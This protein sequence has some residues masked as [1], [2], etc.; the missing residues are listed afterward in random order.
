MFFTQ[1]CSKTEYEQL[2]RPYADIQAFTIAGYGLVDSIDAVIAGDSITIYWDDAVPLPAEISPSI[3]LSAGATI[4]PQANVSVA[5]SRNTVYTVTAENGD[6]REYRL[7]PKP[8]REIPRLQGLLINAFPWLSRS[9]LTLR[10]EYF[11]AAPLDQYKVYMQ[12]LRDGVEF[13]LEID[14]STITP[15]Q[16]TA[17]LPPFTMEQDTG[18]H[19]VW[20]DLGGVRTESLELDMY[21]PTLKN[22]QYTIA[23]PSGTQSVRPG[24]TITIQHEITDD[25]DG[26][27]ARYYQ[28]NN[29]LHIRLGIRPSGSTGALEYHEIG[30]ESITESTIT[31]KIP[32]NFSQYVD[33]DI[34]SSQVTYKAYTM[35]VMWGSYTTSITVS[36][37]LPQRAYIKIASAE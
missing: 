20:V 34:I 13:D 18:M 27:A 16:I 10:G 1:S 5:F 25:S 23:Y 11:M 26:A 31:F 33:Y 22:E 2:K 15:H 36:S 3:S 35:G 30:I 6:K 21:Q 17:K 28:G 37:G 29:I 9:E 7:I 4:E 32:D 12:R 24:Q 8:N 14:P 19:R